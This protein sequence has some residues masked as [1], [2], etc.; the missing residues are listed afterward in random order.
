[1][2]SFVNLQIECYYCLYI[3][4]KGSLEDTSESRRVEKR[5]DWEGK[6]IEI[7]VMSIRCDVNE[8]VKS[9]RE[10]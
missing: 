4:I 5:C 8:E 7:D 1:M 6:G 10:V 2:L 3:F 9:E